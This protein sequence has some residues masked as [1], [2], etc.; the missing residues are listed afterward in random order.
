MA[1]R[2]RKTK[3]LSDWQRCGSVVFRLATVLVSAG[4]L[5][6]FN[7]RG[8]L[9]SGASVTLAWDPPTTGALSYK[10]YYGTASRSYRTSVS[11]G[12][13]NT[14]TIPNLSTGATYYF[15][16]TTADD[17]G[18][19]S[20]YSQEIVYTPGLASLA[21]L[22]LVISPTRQAVLSGTAPAGNKYNVLASQTFETWVN[23]GT[24]TADANGNLQFIEPAPATDPVRCYRLQQT[25]P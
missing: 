9:P 8:I 24:V 23:I 12:S 16:A 3:V 20:G 7:T 5:A 25:S 21:I 13:A 1:T 10:V 15:A 18:A 19:E 2:E 11:A 6:P 4:A 17:S 22:K 14:I